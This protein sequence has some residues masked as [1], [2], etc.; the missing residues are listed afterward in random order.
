MI[1]LSYPLIQHVNQA[2]LES[3]IILL[4]SMALA[5]LLYERSARREWWIRITNLEKNSY[6]FDLSS[7]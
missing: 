5:L 7:N 2:I 3:M 6:H 1:H 4:S